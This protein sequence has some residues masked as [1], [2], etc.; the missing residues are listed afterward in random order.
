MSSVFQQ[1][2]TKPETKNKVFLCCFFQ[3]IL[4]KAHINID[5]LRMLMRKKETD[6]RFGRYRG[7]CLHKISY[8][9]GLLA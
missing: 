5:L 9:K 1:Q 8:Y 4:Q 2:M 7:G 3:R 6:A